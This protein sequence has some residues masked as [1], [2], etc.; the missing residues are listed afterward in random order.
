[1]QSYAASD[2]ITLIKLYPLLKD[3]VANSDL[4]VELCFE[5]VNAHI[6]PEEIKARRRLRKNE[7]DIKELQKK[8]DA[9]TDL[10]RL[11]LSNREVRLIK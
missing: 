11:V 7:G 3:A 10:T 9:C 8:L 4:F 2:V 6:T 5:Q 1:M